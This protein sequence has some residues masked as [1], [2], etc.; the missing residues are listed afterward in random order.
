MMQNKGNLKLPKPSISYKDLEFG[1][2]NKLFINVEFGYLT[3]EMVG[4]YVIGP[5]LVLPY[6]VGS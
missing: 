4:F 1:G 6:K 3:Q 2:E 5:T